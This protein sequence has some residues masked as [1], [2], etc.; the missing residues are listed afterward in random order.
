MTREDMLALADRVE[1]LTGPDRETDE[2]IGM[3]IGLKN[4]IRV[5]HECLGTD[6][7][8]PVRCPAYTA[9]LDSAMS[10][11]PDNVRTGALFFGEGGG[12]P[13]VSLHIKPD[14]VSCKGNAATP[15]LALVAAALRARA[16][17]M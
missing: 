15:A 13:A 2:R 4:T 10:L 14:G 12:E 16:E 11:V 5:G 7:I 17:V 6:R 9:S 1:S 8:V 3:A